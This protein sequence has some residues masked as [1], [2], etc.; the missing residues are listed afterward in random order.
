MTE[1]NNEYDLK[2]QVNQA[3][4]KAF[5]QAAASTSAAITQAFAKAAAS[6]KKAEANDL[7]NGGV[8][9]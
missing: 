2:G 5:S 7:P 6:S 9:E 3:V 4:T 1:A 8:E